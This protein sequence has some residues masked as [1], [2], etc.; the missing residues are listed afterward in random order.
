MSNTP[1][2]QS[3][4]RLEPRPRSDKYERALRAEVRDALWMMTRQWQF[5]EFQAEDSGSAIFSRVNV[6]T[7]TLNK[8]QLQGQSVQDMNINEPLE[9]NIEKESPE[10]DLLMRMEMGRHWE[11]LV[12]TEVTKENA[13]QATPLSNAALEAELELVFDE[14]RSPTGLGGDLNFY[15]PQ[16]IANDTTESLFFS[17]PELY[18][19]TEAAAGRAIDG[20]LLYNWLKTPTNNANIYVT[21]INVSAFVSSTIGSCGTK[22]VQWFE[23]TYSIPDVATESGWHPQHLEYQFACAAPNDDTQSS[24]VFIADEYH[25]GR[26]DW[27]A[28]DYP[29]STSA[30]NNLKVYDSSYTEEEFHTV[31]PTTA[32]FA[33]MPHSRWWKMED[34]RVDFGDINPATTD[35]AKISFSEFALVY[36]ND[37]MIFPYTVPAGS[38]SDIKSLVVTDCFGQRTSISPAN[39]RN[40]NDWSRWSFFGLHTRGGAANANLRLFIPPVIDQLQESEPIESVNFIRDETANMVWGIEK[41]IPNGLGGGMDAYETALKH[42]DFLKQKANPS[43]TTP[44]DND[45]KIE[46][47]ISNTVPENWIP[48][49]PVRIGGLSS[50]EIQLQRA[51]MPRFID[52]LT[53]N[54]IERVRPR[55]VLLSGP[56]PYYIFEEEVPRSGAI[57]K[58][59][60][61][62]TRTETGKIVTWLGRRK[63]NGRGEGHSNLSFDRI[64]DKRE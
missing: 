18:Q 42:V 4:N 56:S 60:W 37:W 2:I 57:V 34:K 53:G 35:I 26:L 45:A 59:T 47:Q 44:A 6:K 46:Y 12:R 39:E 27:Y 28:F 10:F 20:S 1:G 41:I 52:G 17:N 24:H 3:W 32:S 19:A 55:S 43:A 7:S 25:Q 29:E 64:I 33:G 11:N 5:G 61:Q 16:D 54:D 22:F 15:V 30:Y 13:L 49:T 48:F 40:N 21:L 36:S 38:I 31:I 8:Y 58:R 50:R 63:I 23:R 51:A 9:T 62:R 14:Y